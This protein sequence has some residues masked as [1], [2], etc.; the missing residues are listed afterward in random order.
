[1]LIEIRN[2]KIARSLSEE[3]TAY[4]ADI[5]VDG[6]KSFAASNHGHGGCDFFQ[7]YPAAKVTE[8]EVSAYL[9]SHVAPDGPWEDNP[10]ERAPYD[11]GHECDLEAFVGRF[12][13]AQE[14]ERER[15][16]VTAKYIK[17][18]ATRVVGLRGDTFLTF[19]KAVFTP[20]PE[21]IAAVATAN[22]DVTM[23][24]GADE[25]TMQK[26]LRAYCPDLFADEGPTDHAESVYARLRMGA[27]TLADARWLLA[28]SS[29]ENPKYDAHLL[30][31]IAKQ[32]AAY[33]AYCAERD[34][35]RKA[36]A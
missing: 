32:E 11:T 23:L 9:K 2:L 4:T 17:L 22:P 34:A 15:K 20:T 24:N 8:A 33:A 25:A 30:D 16:S 19:G 7:P 31:V 6:V 10:A 28:R 29:G 5:F 26:G 1:M 14:G 21:R 36:A 3:T 18:V 35:A 12:V 13:S 27:E